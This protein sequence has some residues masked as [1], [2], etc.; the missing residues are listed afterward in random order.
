MLHGQGAQNEKKGSSFGSRPIL[1]YIKYRPRLV[2]IDIDQYPHT[3]ARP[4]SKISYSDQDGTRPLL[5][6]MLHSTTPR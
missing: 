3:R 4:I 5:K 6:Y 1:N 2:R